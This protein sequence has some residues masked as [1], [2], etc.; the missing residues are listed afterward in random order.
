MSHSTNLPD[1][2]SKCIKVSGS[3]SHSDCEFCEK[4]Q[5]DEWIFCELNQANRTSESF[6]CGAFRPLL[7]V[8]SKKENSAKPDLPR[9][10]LKSRDITQYMDS[11]KFKYKKALAMQKL[12]RNPDA[13]MVDLKYHMAW[14]TAYRKKLFADFPENIDCLKDVLYE[15]DNEI[16]GYV[17]SVFLSKDHIH[18]CVESDGE[19]SVEEIVQI[20][21]ERSEKAIKEEFPNLSQVRIWDD[22]YFVESMM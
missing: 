14:N 8:L 13:V 9:E 1:L 7:R 3:I 12:N 11:N 2:C 16:G 4:L 20:L 6:K 21:K 15:C 5:F 22:C 10:P 17:F 18:L 19:K